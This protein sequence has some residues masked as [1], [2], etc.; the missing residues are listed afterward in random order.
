MSFPLPQAYRQQYLE[1][2]IAN[3]EAAGVAIAEALAALSEA[4]QQDPNNTWKEVMKVIYDKIK[5]DAQVSTTLDTSLNTTFSAGVPVPQDGGLTLQTA[6]KAA[7]TGGAADGA[8]GT[9]Q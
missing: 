9:L 7:T 1:Q 3:A 2:F 4:Q 5:Q 8:S 6:W